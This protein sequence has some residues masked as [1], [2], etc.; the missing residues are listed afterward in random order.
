MDKGFF[1]GYNSIVWMVIV[2]QVRLID[3]IN[4]ET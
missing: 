3:F 4:T 2:L 1:Q